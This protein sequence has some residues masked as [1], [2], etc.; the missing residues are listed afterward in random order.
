VVDLSGN[1]EQLQSL[2]IEDGSAVTVTGA[3]SSYDAY[4]TCNRATDKDKSDELTERLQ[5]ARG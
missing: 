5:D 3:I 4:N 1:R 2:G